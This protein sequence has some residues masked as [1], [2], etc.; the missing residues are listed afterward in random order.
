MCFFILAGLGGASAQNIGINSTGTAPDPSALLDV[1]AAPTNNKGL[2][3]P[4]FPPQNVM[5]L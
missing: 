3:L 2:L 4:A 5:L 1:N